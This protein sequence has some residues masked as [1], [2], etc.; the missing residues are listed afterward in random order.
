MSD[1]PESTEAGDFFSNVW[2]VVAGIPEGC[3]LSYGEVARRAGSPR[4]A[5]MV[6]RA[7]ARAPKRLE[8]PWH[9][10]VNAQGRISFPEGSRSARRQQELLEAEG[11]VF[12]DGVID[13]ENHG[14]D[15]AM[16]YLLWGPDKATGNS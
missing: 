5:R 13:L 9:R 6:G 10:V 1:K 15:Q 7:M 12:A 8:L 2:E 3:V 16:D 4:R 11:V 14:P